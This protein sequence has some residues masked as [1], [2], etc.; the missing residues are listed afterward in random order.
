MI[1]LGFDLRKIESG[2]RNRHSWWALAWFLSVGEGREERLRS[3]SVSSWKVI[4]FLWA[5]NSIPLTWLLCCLSSPSPLQLFVFSLPFPFSAIILCLP[6]SPAGNP[7]PQT[8]HEL[9]GCCWALSVSG[10]GAWEVI[11]KSSKRRILVTV[12][13]SH[14][15]KTPW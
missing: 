14:A 13:E 10:L 5:L 2:G 8:L 15:C 1:C 11:C 12:S 6:Q 9:A 4:S 3:S 7:P